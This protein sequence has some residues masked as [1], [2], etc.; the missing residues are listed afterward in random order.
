MI[1]NI[2][3]IGELLIDGVSSSPWRGMEDAGS[4]EWLRHSI[5]RCAYTS[6]ITGVASVAVMQV[7]MCSAIVTGDLTSQQ[8]HFGVSSVVIALTVTLTVCGF[9]WVIPPHLIAS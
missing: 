2:L 5:K 4:H 3:G 1:W 9:G 7:A 6:D 8:E